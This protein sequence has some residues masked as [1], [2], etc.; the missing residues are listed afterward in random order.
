MGGGCGGGLGGLGLGVCKHNL[1]V[2]SLQQEKA[3]IVDHITV[4]YFSFKSMYPDSTFILGGDKNDLNVQL[5][6]NIDPSF[7]QI[8]SKPT[9]K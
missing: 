1:Y 7:C 8:V 9:Y 4:N 6:L 3:T 2:L 5:L